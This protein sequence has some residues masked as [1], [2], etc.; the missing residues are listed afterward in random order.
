MTTSRSTRHDPSPAA[1]PAAP[2]PPSAPPAPP[3]SPPLDPGVDDRLDVDVDH[4]IDLGAIAGL[5]DD[6][7]VVSPGDMLNVYEFQAIR[8][9]YAAS[10]A[11]RPD[12]VLMTPYGYPPLPRP[13]LAE[14]DGCRKLPPG[15]A[16]EFAGHPVFWLDEGTKRQPPEESDDAFAI[17]LFLELVDRGHLNPAD[18]RLRNPLVAHGL[19]VRDPDDRD[20][21]ARYQDGAWDPLLC[22]LVVPPNPSTAPG[23]V[24]RE[25]ARVHRVH[26][27]SYQSLIDAFR[28]TVRTALADARATIRGADFDADV[29]RFVQAGE[30]LRQA[31]VAGDPRSRRAALDR[32]YRW[33]L[34]RITQIDGA[35]IVLTIEIDRRAGLDA[36][37]PAAS[38]SEEITRTH[39]ARCEVLERHMSAVY[40]AP[41]DE[42]RLRTLMVALHDAYQSALTQGRLV[43]AHAEQVVGDLFHDAAAPAAGP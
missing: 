19:D 7:P 21:L 43:L 16:L 27:A 11:L 39:A 26:V 33:V 41:A 23:A 20:R 31:A 3:S 9:E 36:P 8:H 4:D 14:P 34:T 32:A 24:A 28:R 1:R 25:A 35:R 29:T 38:Y 13:P 6:Q 10:A 5:G 2:G 17:R 37:R 40:L 15:L 42:E 22:D 12:R 30:A 18:G